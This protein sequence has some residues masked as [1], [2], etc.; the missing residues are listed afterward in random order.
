MDQTGAQNNGVEKKEEIFSK[1]QRGGHRVALGNK[2][3]WARRMRNWHYLHKRTERKARQDGRG[4][5]GAS[6][7][8][9]IQ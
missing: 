9:A 6:E 8:Y 3:S 4:W 1:Q 2:W 5:K 7:I